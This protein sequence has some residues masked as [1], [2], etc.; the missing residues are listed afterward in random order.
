[1]AYVGIRENTGKEGAFRSEP[2]VFKVGVPTLMDMERCMASMDYPAPR[3]VDVCMSDVFFS[4][5]P[6]LATND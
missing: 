3:S 4:G 2:L 6:S 5:I 1:M